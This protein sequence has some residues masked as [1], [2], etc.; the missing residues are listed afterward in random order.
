MNKGVPHLHGHV[1][2]P[3]DLRVSEGKAMDVGVDGNNLVPLSLD[4]ILGIMSK[5]PISS[6]KLSKDHHVEE[7]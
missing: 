4:E 6:L 1:H 3:R 2:L 7:M 5:Q